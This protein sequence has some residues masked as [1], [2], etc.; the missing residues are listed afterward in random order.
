LAALAQA[1]YPLGEIGEPKPNPVRKV[2]TLYVCQ[3]SP[4]QSG[5]QTLDTAKFAITYSLLLKDGAI[6]PASTIWLTCLKQDK[7]TFQL[8]RQAIDKK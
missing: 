4:R 3:P 1:R 6:D 5:L 8:R 7:P 2:G